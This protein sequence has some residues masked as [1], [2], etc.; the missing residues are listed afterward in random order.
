M[1][2][3]MQS[4]FLLYSNEGKM[5]VHT[6]KFQSRS[7]LLAIACSSVMALSA[8]AHAQTVNVRI[9]TWNIEADIDGVT[10]PR[11]GLY[12]AVE[13]MGEDDFDGISQPVDILTLEETTSNSTTI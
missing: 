9:A 11:T 5:I 10:T 12:Q 6:K 4:I 1:P 3:S 13:G 8:T 2:T 7:A